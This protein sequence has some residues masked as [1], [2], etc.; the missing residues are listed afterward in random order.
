MLGDLTNRRQHPSA[1]PLRS[2][3]TDAVPRNRNEILSAA[4]PSYRPTH[5]HTHTLVFPSLLYLLVFA[6]CAD[7]NTF[8]QIPTRSSGSTIQNRDK[9]RKRAA[10]NPCSIN[11]TKTFLWPARRRWLRRLHAEK[12]HMT[13]TRRRC[14]NKIQFDHQTMKKTHSIK[15]QW[16]CFASKAQNICI[17]WEEFFFFSLAASFLHLNSSD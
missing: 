11:A 9:K 5:R 16:Y 6:S 14:M 10:E 17:P 8:Q 4:I 12:L 2:I 15:L 7:A 1:A 13:Q 3:S